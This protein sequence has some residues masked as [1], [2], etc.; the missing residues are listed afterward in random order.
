MKIKI[1]DLKKCPSF[2]FQKFDNDRNSRITVNDEI[3]S[4]DAD[5][6]FRL[7]RG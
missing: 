6:E 4:L 2:A 1:L 7:S 5:K 3:E